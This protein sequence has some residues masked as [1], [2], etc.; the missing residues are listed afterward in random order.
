[1]M[2]KQYNI[3]SENITPKED[4]DC[5]LPPDDPAHELISSQF[6]GGLGHQERMAAKDAKPFSDNR[7][8]V[9]REKNIQPGTPEWFELW[10]SRK[11][12]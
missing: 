2:M 9:M 4:G 12:P 10:F 8:A 6:M 3:T 7:A 11:S 1:M 5:I